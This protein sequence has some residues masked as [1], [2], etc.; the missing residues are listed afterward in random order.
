MA[1]CPGPHAHHPPT[2][3]YIERRT[4]QGLSKLDIL[5]YLKRYIAREAYHDLTAP[6]HDPSR[7]AS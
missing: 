4:K 2:R 5:R 1:H 6:T 7:L 3:A